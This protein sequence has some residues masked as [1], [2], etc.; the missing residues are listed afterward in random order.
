[1]TVRSAVRRAAGVV[2]CALAIVAGGVAVTPAAGAAVSSS[3]SPAAAVPSAAMQPRKCMASPHFCIYRDAQVACGWTAA[4]VGT[5][6]T[7]CA[8]IAR[9]R[10][11]VRVVN[12]TPFRFAYY[13]KDGYRGYLGTMLPGRTAT[14]KCRCQ[15]RS[16]RAVG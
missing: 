8:F 15:V 3:P 9:G 2:G 1:M 12:H 10:A 6:R 16:F 11:V 5:T 14:L 7:S 4:A 13:S